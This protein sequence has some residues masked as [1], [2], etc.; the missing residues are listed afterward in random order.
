MNE[1]FD[2]PRSSDLQFD[3]HGNLRQYV[4]TVKGRRLWKKVTIQ[5]LRLD[6]HT[7]KDI[8]WWLGLSTPLVRRV[9]LASRHQNWKGPR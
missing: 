2:A 4:K 7:Y 1:W 8:A 6:G 5:S 3:T 9:D